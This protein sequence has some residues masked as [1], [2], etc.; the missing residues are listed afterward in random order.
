MKLGENIEHFTYLL[1][2]GYECVFAT[3]Y[4][5][6]VYRNQK[7]LMRLYY[8]EDFN[9]YSMCPEDSFDLKKTTYACRLNSWA[10]DVEPSPDAK[11]I[12]KLLVP[13]I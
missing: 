2:L 3:D 1:S 12:F 11:E 6:H 4:A 5:L 7:L 9:L 10:W 8:D 13:R